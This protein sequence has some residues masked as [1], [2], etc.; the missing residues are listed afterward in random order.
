MKKKFLW[1]LCLLV[2][3]VPLFA[4]MSREQLQRMYLDYFRSQNIQA[5]IDSDGD[6]EFVYEGSYFGEMTFWIIVSE[7]EADQQY[8]Q[9]HISGL[10]QLDTEADRRQAS[11]AAAV[12]TR[13]ANVAKI[14]LNSNGTNVMAS[15]EA[16]LVNPQD[17]RAV[18]PKLMQEM[19]SVM[20][21][22]L[23]EM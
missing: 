12:A 8:F 5:S 15:A 22:F 6:I 3:S 7:T 17:F 19:D 21:Y 2:L 14:Y 4:D 16:F 13:R 18:F 20:Y 23:D 10:Y 9:V 1:A 11:L